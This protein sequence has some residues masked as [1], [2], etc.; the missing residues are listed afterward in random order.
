MLKTNSLYRFS[1]K[2]RFFQNLKA[3]LC[4]HGNLVFLILDAQENGI[5]AVF[6]AHPRH[7]WTLPWDSLP[8][9]INPTEGK[10]MTCGLSSA[11]TFCEFLP[12]FPLTSFI[13][14]TFI[15]FT[16]LNPFFTPLKFI[17]NHSG[18]CGMLSINPKP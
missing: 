10:V 8:E 14:F 15:S 7:G 4:F 11:L 3:L 2:N 6:A 9:A 18:D 13:N 17:E 12:L 5:E 16:S 1:F